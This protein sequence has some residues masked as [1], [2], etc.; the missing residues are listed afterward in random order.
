M[1]KNKNII[2]FSIYTIFSSFI[3]T[4]GIFLVYLSEKGLSMFE[5]ALYQSVF[6]IS[7]T[8]A[9][10]PTGYIGDRFGKEKSMIIGLLLLSVNSLLMVVNTV[11]FMFLV[12]AS[13]DALAYACISGSDRALLYEIL[14]K[15]SDEEKYLK[16]NS[17]ILVIQSAVTGFAVFI[18]SFL[19]TINWNLPYILTAGSFLFATCAIILLIRI[20]NT[21]GLTVEK[22]VVV[23]FSIAS[24]K[25]NITYKNIRIFLLFFVGVSFLDGYFIA[26]YNINQIIFNERGIDVK[27]IGLFFTVAYFVG[28]LTNLAVEPICKR[29]NKL[30][31]FTT[32]LILQGVLVI[33]VSQVNNNI[34]ILLIS[35]IICALPDILYLIY[36]SIIQSNIKSTYRAT[37]LSVNSMIVSLG[38]ALTYAVV[39]YTFEKVGV[40][41]VILILGVLLTIIGMFSSVMLWKINKE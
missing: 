36:D 23:K 25:E 38:A 2:L 26:Y 29:F 3:L 10:V 40:T 22:E 33:V 4:R 30:K 6:F 34:M 20:N 15:T 24:F 11:P 13:S 41:F 14:E 37:I 18:G 8:I 35:L 28:S 31:V 12:L 32:I 1:F 9:E 17:R 16:I 27:L 19:I 7:T 21:K 39:G 5:V